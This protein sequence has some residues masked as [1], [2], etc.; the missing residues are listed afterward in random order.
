MWGLASVSSSFR[1]ASVPVRFIG[2]KS[3]HPHWSSLSGMRCCFIRCTKT[4]EEISSP[5]QI[6]TTVPNVFP[7]GDWAL[8]FWVKFYC[9]ELLVAE[10]EAIY[11]EKWFMMNLICPSA[12]RALPPMLCHLVPAIRNKSFWFAFLM[13]F[14]GVLLLTANTNRKLEM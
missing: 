2:V 12:G 5:H 4:E 8:A 13:H 11:T 10:E 6:K 1:K 7:T 9:W 3:S 14:L